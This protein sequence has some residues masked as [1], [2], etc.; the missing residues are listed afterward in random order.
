LKP[1]MHADGTGF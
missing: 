1:Q